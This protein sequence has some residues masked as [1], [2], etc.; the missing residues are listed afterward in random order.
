MKTTLWNPEELN[1]LLSALQSADSVLL[2]THVSPDGDT[3]GSA[4]ALKIR[5]ERMGKTASVLVH[6]PYPSSLRVLPEI[7]N[8]ITPEQEIPKADLY[9]AVDVASRERLGMYRPIWESAQERWIIDHHIHTGEPFGNLVLDDEAPATGLVVY[10][11]FRKMNLPI[12]A[13]EA[14]CLYTAVSTDTGNFIYD[15]TSAECHAMMAHIMQESGV[16]FGETA[17]ILH[18]EKE[19]VFIKL[20]SRVL[21]ALRLCEDGCICGLSVTQ[22]TLT[23]CRATQADCEGLID[24]AID[25]RGVVLAYSLREME[26][27][28]YKCSLRSKAPYVV[29]H[30]AAGF[31][32]GGHIRAAGCT[33]AAPSIDDAVSLVE[34]ALIKEIHASDK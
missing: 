34:N 10:R 18:R 13:E 32:G 30:I 22:E 11:L 7:G 21:P 15:S 17:R 23:A 19:P 14:V 33:I 4:M 26:D 2:F 16:S 31:G 5:L 20:L 12:S 6:T 9:L 27:G 3:L 28:R 25:T 29:N 8:V 1:R 24:Y